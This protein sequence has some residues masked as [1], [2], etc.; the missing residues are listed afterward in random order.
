VNNLII[1]FEQMFWHGVN[2]SG[3]DIIYCLKVYY[4]LCALGIELEYKFSSFE[5]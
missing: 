3:P 1:Y 5:V 4:A 2:F